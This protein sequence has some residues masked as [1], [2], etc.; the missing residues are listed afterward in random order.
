MK[1]IIAI[2]G[3]DSAEHD[4]SIIT[5][6]EA[7]NACPYGGYK[8]YP[9]YIKNGVWYS[10]ESMLD[11]KTFIDFEPKNH[12]KVALI[13]NK[14]YYEKRGKWKHLDD[15]DCALLLTHGGSG[16]NGELQGLLEVS[17]VP[18]TST[19]TLTSALAMDK[20][21]LKLALKDMKVSVVKG[22][23]VERGCAPYEAVEKALDYPVFVKPNAQGSSIGVGIARDREELMEGLEVAFRYGQSALVERCL[24][25]FV[26]YNCAVMRTGDTVMVSEVEKPVN[27][28]EFLSFEDK[29]MDF[30]K[31]ACLCKREFP[32]KISEELR[33][34]IRSISQKVYEKLHLKGVVRFD[35]IHKN[36]LYLNELNTIPGSLAH[37]LFPSINYTDFLSTL[38]DE[39]IDVGT[40]KYPTFESGVLSAGGSIL[41]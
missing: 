7:L 27:A 40:K 36:R 30:S 1:K 11:L 14:M 2:F 18:Y 26:E 33:T 32:A 5:A 31:T 9:V 3:G 25:D 20:Y 37:Y 12:K 22:V 17:G 23:K 28:G 15:V 8:V 13:G 10:S 39:A 24:E 35:F 4:I 41:K 21:L 6:V 16:E 29:Y 19:D 38:I 34:E